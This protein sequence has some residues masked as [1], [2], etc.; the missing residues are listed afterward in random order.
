VFAPSSKSPAASERPLLEAADGSPQPIEPHAELALHGSNQA[1]SAP[2]AARF[3]VE[4]P[5][6]SMPNLKAAV[7]V[8][9][10][11]NRARDLDDLNNWLGRAANV[12]NASGVIV[13]IGEAAG[14]SLRPV[15]AYGYPAPAL[16]RMPLVA[17]S[18]D[19]AA[20]TAFRT[21][22][23]QMVSH[24][25][26]VSSGALAVPMLSREGCIGALTAEIRNGGE[27]SPGV[28]AIAA[29]LAAQLAGVLADSVP[30]NDRVEESRIASA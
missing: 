20:A 3:P 11:L 5:N 30:A 27:A 23:L 16:A 6:E 15:L 28:Q 4:L 1:A 7:D 29:I 22:K 13:W 18:D 25:P 19:N 26:G 21:E 10:E 17:R 8:C 12:I 9:T 24:R 14:A 2:T